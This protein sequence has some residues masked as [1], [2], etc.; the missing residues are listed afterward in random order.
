MRSLT[1]LLVAGALWGGLASAQDETPAADSPLL[2]AG[3]DRTIARVVV[4]SPERVVGEVRLVKRGDADVVQ[5][6][7]YVKVLS[8]VVAEIRKKEIAN[9]PAGSA[10]HDD[11][12]RYTEA[13][14]RVRSRLWSEQ[15]K[16]RRRA[17][18]RQRMLIE[19][20]LGAREALVAVGTFD[21]EESSAA[22]RLTARRPYVVLRP[23]RQYVARNMVL[24]AADAFRVEGA[25]LAALLGPLTHVRE[26]QVPTAIPAR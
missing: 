8:R 21:M 10:G 25:D 14:D 16:D 1:S 19:F 5:T 17:D 15:P 26:T 7:L 11:M 4:P 2:D 18:R 13:L 12:R 3:A 23:S 20:V 22:P 24:I 6:V 9:W